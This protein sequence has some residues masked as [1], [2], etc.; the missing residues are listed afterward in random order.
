M[1]YHNILIADIFA[2]GGGDKGFYAGASTGLIGEFPAR[3]KLA[4]GVFGEPDGVVGEFGATSVEGAG[5]CQ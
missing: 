4:V 3:V 5:I 2:G 1:P